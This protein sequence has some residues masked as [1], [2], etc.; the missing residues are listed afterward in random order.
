MQQNEN[1]FHFVAFDL[2]L[3]PS[4]WVTLL[5]FLHV[6]WIAFLDATPA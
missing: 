6:I 4:T 5:D 1:F 2:N 3:L